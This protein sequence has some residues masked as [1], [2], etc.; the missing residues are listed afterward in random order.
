MREAIALLTTLGGAAPLTSR[1]LRWFPLAGALAGAL[2]GGCWWAAG[3]WWAPAVAAA[4]VV[5]ADLALTG[6]LHVDGLADSADGL[7]PHL[8]RERRLDVMRAPDI[9]AFG[10]AVVGG[11]LL[12][13]FAALASIRPSVLLLVGLWC[14][15]R[16]LTA[17]V[18]AFVPYA[19]TDGIA[20][21]LLEHAP[22][23]PVVGVVPAAALAALGTGRGG[24]AAV[25][26]GTLAGAGVV[27]LARRR[28]GGFTGDVL[29][30]AIVVTEVVG[31]VV[32]AAKW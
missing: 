11:A 12:C 21:T 13:E 2:L 6:M 24:F 9:G 10:V 27:A 3:K 7:L 4:I 18:P 5:A 19:R 20:S 1:A 16:S 8:T 22:R 25:L 14:A 15:A 32:A 31:L 29:G 26:A 30:A 23:W 17:S 28:V